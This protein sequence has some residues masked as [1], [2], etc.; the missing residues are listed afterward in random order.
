MQNVITNVTI[1]KQLHF[2]KIIISVA[3]LKLRA[4]K[5]IDESLIIT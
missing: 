3:M 1:A 4:I 5:Y 2:A